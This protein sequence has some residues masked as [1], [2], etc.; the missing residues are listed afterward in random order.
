MTISPEKVRIAYKS[1]CDLGVSL[2]DAAHTWTNEQRAA[3][4]R[5]ER[6]LRPFANPN[7]EGKGLAAM[8]PTKEMK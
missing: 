4:E 7:V 3:W 1:L 8:H 2:A 6:S 5:A